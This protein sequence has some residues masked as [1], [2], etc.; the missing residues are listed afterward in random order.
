MPEINDNI[1][2]SEEVKEAIRHM[3][4]NKSARVDDI[5]V[6][7][8]KA[9]IKYSIM[10]QEHLPTECINEVIINLPKKGDSIECN[11]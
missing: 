10:I 4:S 3:R 6:E 7:L 5:F 9:D 11:N 1:S 8:W 2:I